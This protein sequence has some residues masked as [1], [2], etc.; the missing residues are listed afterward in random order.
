[1]SN[2]FADVQ[3]K[4]TAMRLYCITQSGVN[5]APADLQASEDAYNA[6]FDELEANINAYKTGSIESR[7]AQF[8]EV[9]IFMFTDYMLEDVGYDPAISVPAPP[10]PAG[11]T[12]LWELFSMNGLATLIM[13]YSV[14]Y[15]YEAC[16]ITA[17]GTTPKLQ[18]DIAEALIA[19][20]SDTLLR[21]ELTIYL[22]TYASENTLVLL[23]EN[24][25][26]SSQPK[27][28]E[29]TGVEIYTTRNAQDIID[30]FTLTTYVPTYIL[31]P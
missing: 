12:D 8:K 21:G 19:E 5:C 18:A 26:I 9:L 24:M 15:Y 6:Q 29:V 28:K 13:G 22:Q 30:T 23:T 17:I 27:S 11:F 4:L 10:Y 1:M 16:I 3:N 7:S 14:G 20:A 25:T 31:N 2:W